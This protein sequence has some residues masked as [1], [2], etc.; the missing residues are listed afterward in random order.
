M[1]TKDADNCLWKHRFDLLKGFL[2]DATID[3]ENRGFDRVERRAWDP[4]DTIYVS[5]CF[6]VCDSEEHAIEH[7]GVE[8]Y[9]I[10]HL[11]KYSPKGV[12]KTPRRGIVRA[13]DLEGTKE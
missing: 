9:D 8:N 6:E 5:F 4:P 3:I 2:D 12:E 1:K 10:Y 11:S 7:F 13:I